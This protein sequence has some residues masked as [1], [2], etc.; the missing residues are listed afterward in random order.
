VRGVEQRSAENEEEG[1]FSPTMMVA[2]AAGEF[3]TYFG[4]S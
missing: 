2:Q 3:F 1:L 4:E